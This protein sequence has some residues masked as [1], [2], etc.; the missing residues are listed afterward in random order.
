MRSVLEV[1]IRHKNP[2]IIS[3]KSAL[4]LWGLDLINERGQHIWV[5]IAA[6]ITTLDDDLSRSVKPG[7]AYRLQAKCSA[8]SFP[9]HR[10]Y[11]FSFYA[12]FTLSG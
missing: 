3:T 12:D 2:V 4:F 1:L 11:G 10:L 5:N 8:G 9:V 7:Q 6:C